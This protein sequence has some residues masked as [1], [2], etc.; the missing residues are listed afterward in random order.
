M[1][2]FFL[3]LLVTGTVWAQDYPAK[4]VRIVIGFAAGGPT[5]VIARLVSQDMTASMGQAFII[6][7]RPG[8][9]AIRTSGVKAE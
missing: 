4:P 2:R 5:D 1:K 7:N 6:E 3:L 9:N 8:A